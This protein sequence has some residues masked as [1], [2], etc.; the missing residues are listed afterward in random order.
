MPS[1]PEQFPACGPSLPSKLCRDKCKQYHTGS[2]FY[3]S[4]Q[5]HRGHLSRT[6]GPV[7]ANSYLKDQFGVL[8][9]DWKWVRVEPKS[10]CRAPPP[11]WPIASTCW[12]GCHLQESPLL[13]R[14]QADEAH[15]D[16]PGHNKGPALLVSSW[17]SRTSQRQG[18]VRPGGPASSL[19]LGALSQYP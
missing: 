6:P 8:F 4:L 15:P 17:I 16:H 9:P 3:S 7:R 10:Q 12:K 14:G 13:R 19:A 18:L 1:F 5:V 11:Q 2:C